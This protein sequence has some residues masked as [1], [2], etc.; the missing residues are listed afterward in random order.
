[1]YWPYQIIVL[2]SI[3]CRLSNNRA[4]QNSIVRPTPI[5]GRS[6]K[7]VVP[8][9]STDV[10]PKAIIQA[11][12]TYRQPVGIIFMTISNTQSNRQFPRSFLWTIPIN[13]KHQTS[14]V[15]VV[16]INRQ[17]PRSFLWTITTNWKHQTT[18]FQAIPIIG[19]SLKSIVRTIRIHRLQNHLSGQFQL[20]LKYLT[21]IAP[22]IPINRQSPK[23]IV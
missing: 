7:A 5:N 1:M 21:S 15:Q 19:Q 8:T 20:L 12:P 14:I 9:V 16:S 4:L 11:S 18:I 17:S 13:W 10:Y 3:S 6:P 2:Y 23:S 22:T